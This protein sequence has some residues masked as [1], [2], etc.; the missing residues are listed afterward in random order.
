MFQMEAKIRSEIPTFERLLVDLMVLMVRAIRTR[1]YV[2]Q[3]HIEFEK[4]PLS[5]IPRN[6]FLTWLGENLRN[7]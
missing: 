1:K 4:K 5:I 2:Y 3:R 6:N 7:W